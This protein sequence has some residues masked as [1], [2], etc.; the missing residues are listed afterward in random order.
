MQPSRPQTETGCDFFGRQGDNQ[1][2]LSDRLKLKGKG[3]QQHVVVEHVSVAA[4]GQAI[5]GTVIPGEGGE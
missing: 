4:G 5:V 3:G 2:D 1:N